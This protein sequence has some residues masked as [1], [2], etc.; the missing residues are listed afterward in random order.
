MSRARIEHQPALDGVRAL[1]VLAVLCFHGQV[2]GFGGG[3]LGVSVFF[4]LS[5][6]LITS[7]LLAEHSSN[8]GGIGPAVDVPAFY[9][10]RAKRLLPASLLCLLS[11]AVIAAVTDWF[12]AVATLRRDLLGSLLQVANWVF[13]AGDGSYQKLFAQVAGQASPFEHYWSLAI[14]EQFYWLWPLAFLGLCRVARTHRSRTTVLGAATLVLAVAAP[15][16]AVVWGPDA[17]YWATPARAAEILVGALAAFVVRGRTLP[18]SARWLAPGALVVLAV[19]V[20]LFPSNHGPAFHGALP[21]V[22]LVSATLVVG[23][24]VPSATV[25]ALSWRPFTWLGRIS[26]GVYLYHWPVFVLLAPPRVDLAEPWRFVAR[27]AITL[28]LAQVSF[29]LVERPIRTGIRWRPSAVGALAFAATATVAVAAVVLVPAGRG[30]YWRTD[31]VAA[32]EI[33]PVDGGTLAPLVPVAVTT[34]TSVS[35]STTAPPAAVPAT[36]VAATST[37]P[38]TSTTSTLAPLPVLAR[39]V[40]IVVA[41]DSTAEATGA[42]LA[43]W[44]VERP[45]LAQVTIDAEK[46]CGFVRGGEIFVQDWVGIDARCERWVDHG[47]VDH[48][49]K[50]TPDVVMLMTTSWDV[51]DRRWQPD[52]QLSP[53]DPPFADRIRADFTAIT[54]ELLAAGAGH[55]VWVREL[56]PNVFWWSSGQS[57]EDP[58][59]H[60][61]LYGVMDDLAASHP[62]TVSVVDLPTWI[63]EQGLTDDHDARPDGVHWSTE[64]AGRIAREF[65]GD[66]LVRAALGM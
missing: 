31:A 24:Q 62:G 51:L 41:G 55:V 35:T 54:D 22:G 27:M 8:D 36:T 37:L 42:G 28:V 7:L 5:G 38:P 13:L 2:A 60:Q 34:T 29:V 66:R 52:E 33:Q 9:V 48:V 19:C 61:V 23:L 63:A 58:A 49:A 43:Q 30:D 16:I 40:R 17:A 12:D 14:E 50:L 18:S 32:A 44:A 65:L 64:V 11:V 4:T 56:V 1:S 21:L 10:R 47:L 45:D 39:P 6:F 15:V 20:V 26:Y 53:L 46:G 3:Y 25:R 57:Q 59:R